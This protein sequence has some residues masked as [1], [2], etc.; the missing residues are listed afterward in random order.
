MSSTS[1]ILVTGANGFVGERACHQW[2]EAIAWPG[3]DLRQRRAVAEATAALWAEFGFDRVVH[4]AGLSSI[5]N[6]FVDPV[7]LFEV[8]VLGTVHLLQA[9]ADL[10]WRGRFLYVSS[11]AVYGDPAT[12]AGPLREESPLAPGSPYAAS[13][14]A[15]EQAVLEWGRRQSG[16]ESLVARP[17]NHSG[18]GQSTHFFLPSMAHQLTRVA[19]GEEVEIATGN[20]APYRDFLHVDDVLEAYRRLLQTGRAGQ[21]YNVASGRSEPLA[22]MLQELIRVS[23]RQVRQTVDRERF[24]G[25]Q[26][27]PVEMVN[28]R[29]REDTGWQPGKSLEELYRDLI[30]YWEA[31]DG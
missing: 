8:N 9:L 6:S 15:A 31:A 19:P 28:A 27:H 5:Q 23:R 11:A 22:S 7:A 29:L 18:P 24:R 13:K 3:V 21:I 2:A 30:A 16:R 25:E 4:L 12:A 17:S 26:P 20:L 10:G 1:P 14:A